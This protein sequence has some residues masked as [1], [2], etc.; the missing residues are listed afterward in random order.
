MPIPTSSP[1]YNMC[2]DRS[3]VGGGRDSNDTDEVGG[4]IHKTVKEVQEFA[5]QEFKA[6]PQLNVARESAGPCYINEVLY[7]SGG[8]NAHYSYSHKLDSI[9]LLHITTSGNG[10]EWELCKTNLP[11][12]VAYHTLTTFKNKVILIGGALGI[13]KYL[14]EVWEGT[15]KATNKMTWEPMPSMQ[16]ERA[17]HFSIVVDDNIYVFG[18]EAGSNKSVV[19]VFDGREWKE[20]PSFYFDLDTYDSHAEETGRRG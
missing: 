4:P 3:I 16:K 1:F 14:N 10:L 8:D 7:V 19:E 18:G 13:Y 12:K 6:L 2:D 15:L 20:G 9:E 11:Y 5:V 17:G